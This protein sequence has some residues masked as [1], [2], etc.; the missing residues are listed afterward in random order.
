MTDSRPFSGDPDDDLGTAGKPI[1][2]FWPSSS[3]GGAAV[4][5]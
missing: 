3:A 4:P 2:P 5:D 1:E